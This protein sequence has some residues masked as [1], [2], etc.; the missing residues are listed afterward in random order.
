MK[1]ISRTDGNLAYLVFVYLEEKK[2]LQEGAWGNAASEGQGVGAPRRITAQLLLLIERRLS[3]PLS[4]QQ[5]TLTDLKVPCGHFA[6]HHYAH[7]C[8]RKGK[9]TQEIFLASNYIAERITQND[10]SYITR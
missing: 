8:A 3:L 2:E 9:Q 1:R 4:S 10:R 7:H 5:T 6:K